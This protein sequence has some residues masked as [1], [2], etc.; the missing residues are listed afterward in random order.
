MSSTLESSYVGMLWWMVASRSSNL[1]GR[2]G[3]M[4]W[5]M[6]HDLELASQ[7]PR[8]SRSGSYL[9]SFSSLQDRDR[10]IG[11]GS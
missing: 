5:M 9:G 7:D 6:T 1:Y 4:L 3:S 8:F 10:K 2:S 11:S